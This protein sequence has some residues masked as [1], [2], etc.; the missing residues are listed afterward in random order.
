L[1][2][3]CDHFELIAYWNRL[4]TTVFGSSTPNTGF[5]ANNNNTGGGLFGGGGGGGGA[6]SGFGSTGGMSML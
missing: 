5:G 2:L 3:P 1:R 4:F 6:T